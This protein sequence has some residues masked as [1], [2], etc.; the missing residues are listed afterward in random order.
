MNRRNQMNNQ[1]TNHFLNKW[2]E[3]LKKENCHIKPDEKA[4]ILKDMADIFEKNLKDKPRQVDD[5]E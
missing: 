3:F 1:S 4:E 2:D 5:V